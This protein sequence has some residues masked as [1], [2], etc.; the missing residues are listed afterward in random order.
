MDEIIC[1]LETADRSKLLERVIENVGSGYHVTHF[2]DRQ[3]RW[4]A[5]VT[6]FKDC[7]LELVLVLYRL[8]IDKLQLCRKGKEKCKRFQLARMETIRDVFHLTEDQ[9]DEERIGIII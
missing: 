5:I 3:Q 2:S 6:T 8:Y 4:N 1:A 7:L 9:S